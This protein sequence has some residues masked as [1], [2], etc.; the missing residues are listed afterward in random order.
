L[1]ANTKQESSAVIHHQKT[2]KQTNHPDR[3]AAN[4]FK[5]SVLFE[6][7][8]PGGR[9]EAITSKIDVK[10]ITSSTELDVMEASLDAYTIHW[11]KDL[12][13]ATHHRFHYSPCD[14]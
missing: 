6:L 10:A 2:E 9:K 7:Q 13:P 14:R 5:A 4:I 11:L 1:S 12:Q 8:T 3:F